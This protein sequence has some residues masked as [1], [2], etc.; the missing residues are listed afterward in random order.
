MVNDVA[1]FSERLSVLIVETEKHLVV[2]IKFAHSLSE[3][4]DSFVGGVVQQFVGVQ[5]V[6]FIWSDFHSDPPLSR[7]M[8]ETFQ[9]SVISDTQQ[10]SSETCPLR[11]ITVQA[12][13]GF[14]QRILCH[15]L[16]ILWRQDDVCH[17]LLHDFSVSINEWS[18]LLCLS[19]E[20]IP[21]EGEVVGVGA[22][23]SVVKAGPYASRA[24]A[25]KDLQR[26]KQLGYQDAFIAK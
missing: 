1:N 5:V 12:L 6:Q 16:G 11:I 15:L 13:E 22:V 26:L 25:L 3:Q 8:S 21:D 7:L 14:H 23:L 18:E 24:E 4:R 19:V 9:R 2:G 20:H 10:P 17:K